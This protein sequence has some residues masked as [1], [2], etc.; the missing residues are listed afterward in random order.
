MT[1]TGRAPLKNLICIFYPLPRWRWRDSCWSDRQQMWRRWCAGPPGWVCRCSG[2]YCCPCPR[3]CKS[4]YS[5]CQQGPWSPPPPHQHRHLRDEGIQEQGKVS[6]MQ[7]K[8]HS[9]THPC[10][11]LQFDDSEE[12]NPP[13]DCPCYYLLC[14]RQSRW[15]CWQCFLRAPGLVPGRWPCWS[16]PEPCQSPPQRGS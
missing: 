14:R 6:I 10:R 7:V 15:P 1:Y 13:S 12:T 16:L 4:L 5:S 2:N 9:K 11:H 3:C 8:T